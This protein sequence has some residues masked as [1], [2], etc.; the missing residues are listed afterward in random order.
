MKIKNKEIENSTI[1][2]L[3]LNE[4]D[5]LVIS[6]NRKGEVTYIS[7]TTE[8]L[9]GYKS[10]KLLGKQWWS[11]TFFS[12]EK[13]KLFRDKIKETISGK[14]E[15][16]PTPYRRKLKCENGNVKW[17]E[18]RDSLSDNEIVSVGTD[19]TYWKKKEASKI[20]SDKI[21]ENINSLV[22]VSN[23]KDEIIYSSPSV[24]KMLGYEVEEIMGD[25]WWDVTYDNKQEAIKTKE[26]I[27]NYVNFS[28]KNFVDISKRKIKARNGEYKW[29]EWHISKGVNDTYISVGTDITDRILTDI[30]LKKAKESAEES[31]KVKNEFLANMSHEIR[32]PLNAIIGFTDLLLETK[33]TTE[34]KLH[35]ET[36]QN[37]GEILLSL[38]N[39]VLDLSKLESGKLEIE[40]IPFN[41][42]KQLNEVVRL[43]KIKARE[44]NISLNLEIDSNTPKEV[45]GD[46]TRLGQILLNLIGNAIK[47]TNKGSVT[48]SVKQLKESTKSTTVF[49]EI[50]DTGI[51]IVSNKINTVFGA[52]TQAKSDTSR[53]YGGTGLGLTIVKKLVSLLSGQITVES[54]FGK[55]SVFKFTLPLQ[56][57]SSKT[58]VEEHEEDLAMDKPLNLNI[59]LV[60]DNKTNQLLGKTRLKRW[61]C[62]VDLANNGIEGVKK[63]Q[64]KLYD[65]I[66]MDIQMPI[67]DGYEATKIIKNDISEQVSKIPVIAMTAYTSK[68]DIKRAINAG[69]DDYIFKPFKPAEVYKLL[70][71]YGKITEE[72][73]DKN[74]ENIEKQIKPKSKKYIDLKFIREETMN[75]SSILALLIES[76]INDIDEFL[77]ILD[78]GFRSKN[79][80][81]LHEATH[82]IKP[83]IRM[84]GISKLDQVIHDL[85]N[86]F[87]EKQQ[88]NNVDERINLCNEI[89]KDVKTELL[90]ELKLL[91]DEQ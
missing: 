57:S 54:K 19:I 74:P 24:K 27:N 79:W 22:M 23:N 83:S 14:R 68:N 11:L 53:I 82:K 42:H 48:V 65:V 4:A 30:E 90:T 3:L 45:V 43:M 67:M 26:A 36:M 56:K 15:F 17:I 75:E 50:Q 84:F 47:F 16:N 10:K 66:L 5:I 33:L 52:F 62:N 85:V 69:M 39:D 2:N 28:I 25:K 20:Q 71:K 8:K 81:L 31:L 7:P 1:S 87:R 35:L 58:K 34:Q 37:S 21:L 9:I 70:K 77:E 89:L 6:Y 13:S 55:G 86:R 63:T 44:K 41:L 88:L 32:T 72:N 60:D 18:W 46:P 49:F 76:F 91:K 61:G 78:K 40:V 59:L 38:I 73:N 80:K 64:Q 51:G 29:I 12:K